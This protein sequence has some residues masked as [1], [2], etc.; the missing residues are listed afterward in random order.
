M[1]WSAFILVH[2]ITILQEGWQS[3]SDVLNLFEA[4]ADDLIFLIDDFTCLAYIRL[5]W[6]YRRG[7]SYS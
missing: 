2:Y 3:I 1:I 5:V 4:S 7:L 6:L